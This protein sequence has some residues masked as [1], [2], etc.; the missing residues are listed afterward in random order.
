MQLHSAGGPSIT[1]RPHVALIDCFCR[2]IINSSWCDIGFFF[3]FGTIVISPLGLNQMSTFFMFKRVIQHE[4]T[5][6]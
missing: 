4:P 5:R 1:G 2:V 3:F 6:A